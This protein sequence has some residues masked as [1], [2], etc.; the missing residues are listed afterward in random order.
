MQSLT[1]VLTYQLVTITTS[2]QA[3]PEPP[4]H[5]GHRFLL[6]SSIHSGFPEEQT[7]SPSILYCQLYLACVSDWSIHQPI[8]MMQALLLLLTRHPV[9]SASAGICL[10]SS[11]LI[12]L[13]ALH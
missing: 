7:H 2:D 8:P 3:S 4:L 10:I 6:T 12:T 9:L 5:S 11:H 13:Q 1:H